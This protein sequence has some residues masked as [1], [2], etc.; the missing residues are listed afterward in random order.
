[1]KLTTRSA[2]LMA[3]AS[4]SGAAAAAPPDVIATSSGNQWVGFYA[5]VNGGGAW[6]STCNNWTANGPLANTAAFNN[7]NCPNNSTGIGGVQIGYNFQYEQWV[8]GFGLD[9][10]FLSSKTKNRSVTYAGAPPPPNGTY[11]FSGKVSPNGFLILGPR[12]AYA[13][14]QWLP[15]LRAGGVFTSG[16]SNS[17]ATFTDANGTATFSGGRN[18]K[19][20]GFGISAGVDYMFSDPWSLRLDYTYINLGKG[21]NS[22]TNCSPAGSPICAQFGTVTLDSIHNSFTANVVRVGINYKF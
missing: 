10:E 1:M 17:T 13:F 3:L 15:F 21:S 18:F 5:G 19:S 9:Y 11:T 2:A 20:N 12:I 14:D 6:N 8:W 4:I 16:S 7:R 22:N